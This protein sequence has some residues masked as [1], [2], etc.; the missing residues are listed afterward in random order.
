VIETAFRIG[1]EEGFKYIPFIIAASI[2][3]RISRFPD[4]GIGGTFLLGASSIALM[5]KM[6]MPIPVIFLFSIFVGMI[7]GF[8]TGCCYIYL[9]LNSLICGI[10]TALASY[11]ISFLLM[12]YKST[13]ST[14]ISSCSINVIF[15]EN[16]IGL[17]G[18]LLALL[19]S[20]LFSTRYGLI[21]KVSGESPDLLRNLGIEP[22]YYLL[23]LIIT[24]NIISAISGTLIA[25]VIGNANLNMAN[26]KLL[27]AITALIIGEGLVLSMLAIINKLFSEKKLYKTIASF[28]RLAILGSGATLLLVSGIIGS[29]A[30]WV[31]YNICNSIFPANEFN[32]LIIGIITAFLLLMSKLFSEKKY[33]TLSPWKFHGEIVD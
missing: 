31:I 2:L 16:M 28:L 14:S 6:D 15:S 21:I 10:I 24:G 27:L 17:F 25:G 29:F 8:I 11:T 18:I 1:F 3:F 32:N 22:K 23:M 13:S 26:D 4:M 19:L 7:G 12:N 30:Y 5:Q 33:F 20:I 9:K